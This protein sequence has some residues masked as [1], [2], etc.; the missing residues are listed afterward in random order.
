MLKC[1]EILIKFGKLILD[2]KFTI[3]E[4]AGHGSPA[5]IRRNN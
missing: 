3:S 5:T 1:A 4:A 2:E